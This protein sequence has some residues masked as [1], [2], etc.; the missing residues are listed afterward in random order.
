MNH[1]DYHA[2]CAYPIEVEEY[3]F[4]CQIQLDPFPSI[5]FGDA[6]QFGQDVHDILPVKLGPFFEFVQSVRRHQPWCIGAK[7]TIN[8]GQEKVTLN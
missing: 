3:D 5:V 6:T 7:I 2:C 8:G 4:I 1:P